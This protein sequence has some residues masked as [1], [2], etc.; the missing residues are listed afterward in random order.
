MFSSSIADD[1][2]DTPHINYRVSQLQICRLKMVWMYI[3][4]VGRKKKN[5]DSLL[6]DRPARFG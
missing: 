6:G 1:R 2:L 4:S 5:G 3:E